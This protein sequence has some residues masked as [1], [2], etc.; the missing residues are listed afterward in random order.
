MNFE[1][2]LKITA[3]SLAVI[4]G[5]VSLASCS[6]PGLSKK[7]SESTPA[8]TTT[9]TAI[10][11]EPS[12]SP[13]EVIVGKWEVKEV[14]DKNGNEVNL[15]DVDLSATPLSDYAGI[16]GMVLKAG[17]TIEFKAD[18]TI[19]LVITSG[20]YEIDGSELK[21]SIPDIS[22]QSITTDFEIIGNTMKIEISGYTIN[23][24]KK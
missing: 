22:A 21:I 23:L 9:A 10:Q 19:P 20:K 17:V 13:E 2:T 3:A 12:K 15:S 18:N 14:T 7:G 5:S 24:T 4:I 6:I 1:K 11:T 8:E 16:I